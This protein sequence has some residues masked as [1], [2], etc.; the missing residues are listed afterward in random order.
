VIR[1]GL[2]CVAHHAG[3]L[4]DLACG[5]VQFILVQDSRMP[6]CLIASCLFD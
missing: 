5:R 4:V 2:Q 1:S 6:H 3:Q